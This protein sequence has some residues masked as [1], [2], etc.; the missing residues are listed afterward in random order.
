MS[1]INKRWFKQ[2]KKIDYKILIG[3]LCVAILFVVFGLFIKYHPE[4]LKKEKAASDA[5]PEVENIEEEPEPEEPAIDPEKPMIA[6]T[7]D[8]GPSIY[9]A[10][11]LDVLEQYNARATFFMIGCNVP[12]YPETVQR[13]KDMG[14]ELGN[15]SNNHIDLTTLSTEEM[16]SQIETTNDEVEAVLGERT[17]MVRPPYGEVNDAV[18]ANV[19]YPLIMWSID[20]NDWRTKEASTL[21]EYVLNTVQDGDVILMHDLYEST[22]GAVEELVPQLIERGYQLVTVSEL[23]QMRGVSLESGHRYFKFEK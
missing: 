11:I 12:N 20:T 19:S 4:I 16:L 6:L 5:V 15:H 9:T 17:E 2:R 23:A 21:A 13:I 8:D 14:C 18:Y 10:P 3:L 1:R 22:V 7:F